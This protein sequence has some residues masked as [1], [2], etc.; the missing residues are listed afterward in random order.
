MGSLE[1]SSLSG[2]LSPVQTIHNLFVIVPNMVGG[3]MSLLALLVCIVLP[4]QACQRPPCAITTELKFHFQPLSGSAIM[5]ARH[6]T[7]WQ[8]ASGVDECSK[9]QVQIRSLCFCA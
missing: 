2:L 3:A 5:Y 9:K 7:C 6:Q 8:T 4:R 1:E